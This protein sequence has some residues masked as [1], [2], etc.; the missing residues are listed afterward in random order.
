MISKKK[1]F[2]L[3]V[4]ALSRGGT[5]FDPSR[6]HDFFKLEI[7]TRKRE[8]SLGSARKGGGGGIGMSPYKNAVHQIVT[9][10]VY[11]YANKRSVGDYPWRCLIEEVQHSHRAVCLKIRTALEKS[12]IKTEL[13]KSQHKME[14]KISL[15]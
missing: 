1:F 9:S 15:R 10:A 3:D 4:A 11:N 2:V 7:Y 13:K 6:S 14:S 12:C 5:E 8:F